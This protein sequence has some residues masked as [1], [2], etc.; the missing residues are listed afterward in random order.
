MSIKAYFCSMKLF[1][2]I[3]SIYIFCLAIMP[4]SDFHI[5]L[6]E[7]E[8]SVAYQE[9]HESHDHDQNKDEHC[10]PFCICT[11]CHTPMNFEF[12]QKDVVSSIPY[13]QVSTDDNTFMYYDSPSS[14]YL[15]TI[16][17]PPK[18]NV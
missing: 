16:W 15:N 2:F 14:S 3:L 8:Y 13:T 10:S 1:S 9:D 4:C 18:V 11:C 12:G 5:V 17:Q 6:N 7:S